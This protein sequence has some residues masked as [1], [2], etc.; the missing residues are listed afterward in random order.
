MKKSFEANDLDTG[1]YIA[2]ETGKQGES[3]TSEEWKE[4]RWGG[5]GDCYFSL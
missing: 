1:M 4:L 2:K 3:G 5:V